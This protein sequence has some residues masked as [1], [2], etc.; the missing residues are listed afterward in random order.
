MPDKYAILGFAQNM[1]N[2]VVLYES[3]SAIDCENWQSG[4]T[5]FGDWGGYDAMALYEIAPYQSADTIHNFDAP[6]ID[7]ERGQE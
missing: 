2:P 7:W 6:I 1:K 5:R 3:E 4:Y